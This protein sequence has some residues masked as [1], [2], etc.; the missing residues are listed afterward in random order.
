FGTQLYRTQWWIDRV[1]PMLGED[2]TAIA[3]AIGIGDRDG[4]GGSTD[5]FGGSA[6][7]GNGASDCPA[8][9]QVLIVVSVTAPVDGV[10]Q[11]IAGFI[12]CMDEGLGHAGT[13]VV[14]QRRT[15]IHFGRLHVGEND[16]CP[17]KLHRGVFIGGWGITAIVI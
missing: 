14:C 6:V 13:L 16:V 9:A 7:R 15:H 5:I 17:S 8:I 1:Y 2:I 11:I 4:L 12:L 10:G 3:R